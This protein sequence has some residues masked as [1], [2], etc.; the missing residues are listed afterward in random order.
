MKSACVDLA[1]L[2]IRV[3]AVCPGTID[4]P[5]L[6]PLHDAPELL[7]KILGPTSPLGRVGQA[8]EIAEVL[9]SL[10]SD[11]ASYVNGATIQ[12]DGGMTSTMGPFGTPDQQIAGLI[13]LE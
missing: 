13:G 1:P 11:A 7:A 4:T 9:A 12:I 3:N 6:G 10:V 2:G 5:I 8:A